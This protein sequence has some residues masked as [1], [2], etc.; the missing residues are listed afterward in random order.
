MSDKLKGSQVF[1]KLDLKSSYNQIRIRSSNEVKIAFK[2]KDGLYKW[3]VMPFNLCNAPTTF[4]RLM[5]QVLKS[6]SFVVT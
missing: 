2:T 1:S 4:M 3:L 6:L 5:N